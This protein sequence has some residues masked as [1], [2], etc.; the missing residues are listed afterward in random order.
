MN[1]FISPRTW[2]SLFGLIMMIASNI[3]QPT[4][5]VTRILEI[6]IITIL[7][8]IYSEWLYIDG[9]NAIGKKRLK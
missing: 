6:F 3:L 9:Y 7:I 8:V 4:D 5:N 2:L 1:S